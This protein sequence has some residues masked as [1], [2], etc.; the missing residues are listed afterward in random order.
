M[1]DK[2]TKTFTVSIIFEGVSAENPLD[3]TRTVC[4]WL[5]GS[6]GAVEM[7]YDVIDENTKETYSVDLNG[8][9]LIQYQHK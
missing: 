8:G 9:D 5:L 2:E 7:V 3:A 6:N 1:S 4:N